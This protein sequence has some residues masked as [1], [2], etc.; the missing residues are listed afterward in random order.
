MGGP[1]QRRQEGIGHRDDAEDVRLIDAAEGASIVSVCCLAVAGDAR[2][3]DQ[4]VQLAGLAGGCGDAR[5]VGDVDDEQPGVAT[6]LPDGAFSAR[7][8]AGADPN[9]EAGGSELARDLLADALVGTGD[10]CN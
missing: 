1:P 5:R 6:D 9:G 7:G 4:D 10:Q 8:V 2:V 3:V